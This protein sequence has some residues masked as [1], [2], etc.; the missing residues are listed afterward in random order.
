MN[1]VLFVQY[2]FGVVQKAIPVR[3]ITFGEQKT[4]HESPLPEWRKLHITGSF[5]FHHD[6]L[7]YFLD[8]PKLP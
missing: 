8:N 3:E 1:S 7:Q 4:F 2:T 5:N 6:A